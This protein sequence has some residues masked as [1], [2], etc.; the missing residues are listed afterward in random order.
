[1]GGRGEKHTTGLRKETWE[2]TEKH[3]LTYGW[4]RACL[5]LKKQMDEDVDDGIMEM[6]VMKSSKA[7]ELS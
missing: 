2:G 1:M 3:C 4:T 7:N 5:D 6:K